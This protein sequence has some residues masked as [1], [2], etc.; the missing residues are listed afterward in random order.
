MLA[1]NTVVSLRRLRG[2]FRNRLTMWVVFK[3]NQMR[4]PEGMLW[5]S[6]LFLSS[7]HS[8]PSAEFVNTLSFWFLGFT[9]VTQGIDMCASA[10]L[11]RILLLPWLLVVHCWGGRYFW[12]GGICQ[13]FWNVLPL[14]LCVLYVWI[15]SQGGYSSFWQCH[16]SLQKAGGWCMLFFFFLKG[17]F[18]V[19]ERDH[20]SEQGVPLIHL[21]YPFLPLDYGM[22]SL[23][24]KWKESF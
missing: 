5:C 20:K 2:R 22:L 4:F 10:L 18:Q 24:K 1:W 8:P 14:F 16:L 13:C 9:P 17:L 12:N 3:V 21:F 6:R 11:T 19:S 15:L 23:K 7:G